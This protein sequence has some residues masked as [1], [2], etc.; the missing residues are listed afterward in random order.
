MPLLDPTTRL[1]DLEADPEQ[2]H[3]I[4]DPKREAAIRNSVRRLLDRAEAPT[5]LYGRYRF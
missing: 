5:E 2:K 3:P 4:D 1:F